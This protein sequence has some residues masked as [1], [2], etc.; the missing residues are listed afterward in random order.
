MALWDMLSAVAFEAL[1]VSDGF[2]LGFMAF[3]HMDF[4][5]LIASIPGRALRIIVIV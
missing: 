4:A 1:V 5:D 2:C 3:W